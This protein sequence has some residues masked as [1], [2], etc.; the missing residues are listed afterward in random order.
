MDWRVPPRRHGSLVNWAFILW[1]I[2]SCPLCLGDPRPTRVE[3]PLGR[4][5][6]FVAVWNAPSELCTR[7]FGL[8]FD[9]AHFPMVSTTRTVPEQQDTRIFYSRALGNY[10]H[11]HEFTGQEFHGGVPQQS[12]VREHLRKAERDIEQLIPSNRS[13]G[14][15]VIDWESWRPSWHR[16]WHHKLIYQRHSVELVQQRDLS[17]TPVEASRIAKVEFEEAAKEFLT[18]SLRLGKRMRPNQLWGFYLFPDCYNYDHKKRNRTYTGRCPGRA[19]ARNDDLLWLW[20]ESTALY[21]SIYLSRL[22]RSSRKARLFVRHRVQE[23]MRVGALPKRQHALPVYPYT[24][25]VHHDATNETLA[26]VDLVNTIGESAALG[27]AGIVVWESSYSFIDRDSCA[28]WES[29]V[30]QTLSPYVLNVTQAAR[31]CSRALCKNKGRC[32]RKDW[33]ASDYL[34]LNPASF[35]LRRKRNGK[36]SAVGKASPEDLRFMSERFTCQCYAGKDCTPS[37][38]SST[39][40]AT[41]PK[42]FR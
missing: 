6:P 15:A 28:M 26:E 25:V 12:S 23:A 8:T 31:L 13:R 11:Y 34:H 18:E 22:L 4:D 39:S 2:S 1:G 9:L 30:N 24:R 29:Y 42:P 38:T 17:L 41:S 16:N 33:R 32:V 20:E 27:S 14:L 3:P 37:V 5:V 36:L 40:V 19:Q 35:R 21:P 7:R 10:P